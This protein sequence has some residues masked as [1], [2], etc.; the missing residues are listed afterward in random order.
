MSHADVMCQ[1][2]GGEGCKKKLA[3][4]CREGLALELGA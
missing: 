3:S 2:A 4:F 1:G